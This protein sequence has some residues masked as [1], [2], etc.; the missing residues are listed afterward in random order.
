[1][2][3]DL[4]NIIMSNIKEAESEDKEDCY[5]YAVCDEEEIEWT[6]RYIRSFLSKDFRTTYHTLGTCVN[7]NISW[8]SLTHCHRCGKCIDHYGLCTECEQY[9]KQYIQSKK[10]DI[11]DDDPPPSPMRRNNYGIYVYEPEEN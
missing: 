6:D 5:I 7:L 1:M 3:R 2:I 8:G 10:Q 11:D 4:K 9:L